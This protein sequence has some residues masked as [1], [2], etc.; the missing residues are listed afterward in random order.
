MFLF[1]KHLEMCFFPTIIEVLEKE[2]GIFWAFV[3]QL[4]D[5]T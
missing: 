4:Q 1:S 2:R 3:F 5:L